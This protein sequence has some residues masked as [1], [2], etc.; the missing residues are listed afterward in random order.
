MVTNATARRHINR[1]VYCEIAKSE[2]RETTSAGKTSNYTFL[3]VN[4]KLSSRVPP[5]D[6]CS[7]VIGQDVP[8][9]SQMEKPRAFASAKFHVPRWMNSPSKPLGRYFRKPDLRPSILPLV[10]PFPSLQNPESRELLEKWRDSSNKGGIRCHRGH[11]VISLARMAI[12]LTKSSPAR[13]P[14]KRRYH[15]KEK[16]GSLGNPVFPEAR[17]NRR[18]AQKDG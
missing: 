18:R 1:N 9:E 12:Q 14:F 6:R 11:E 15:W 5:G 2:N 17:T 13:T 8:A 7:T 10:V 3:V 16:V 4:P